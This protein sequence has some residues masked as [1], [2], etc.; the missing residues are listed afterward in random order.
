MNKKIN[1]WLYQKHKYMYMTIINMRMSY[2]IFFGK[3]DKAK[4]LISEHLE[5]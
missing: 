4:V 5:W 2:L 1:K 3:H